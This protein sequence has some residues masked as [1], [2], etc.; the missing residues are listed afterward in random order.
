MPVGAVVIQLR[1]T[2]GKLPGF[3]AKQPA[4][5]VGME[6]CAAAHHWGRELQKLGH[7]VRLMPPRYVKPYLKRQKNDAADV[8]AICEAVTRP[9][10][11]F[12]RDQDLRAASDPGASP[13]AANAD[14]PACA[15]VERD[16]GPYGGDPQNSAITAT[17]AT[18]CALWSTGSLFGAILQL[19]ALNGL[20]PPGPRRTIRPALTGHRGPAADCAN[21][22]HAVKGL[23]LD[24]AEHRTFLIRNFDRV[25][26][27]IMYRTTMGSS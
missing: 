3:F 18:R 9:K 8:E 5:L 12:C 20:S 11:A 4:C 21:S 15:V 19:W 26:G 27:H 10:H 14:M 2:R 1:L 24:A 7:K 17:G 22:S 16:P 25:A 23:H 6:A 13:S